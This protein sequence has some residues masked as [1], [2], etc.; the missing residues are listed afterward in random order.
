LNA[1][2]EPVV[3]THGGAGAWHTD[4]GLAQVGVAR[5]ADA[6]Y[7]VLAAGGSA[8]DAVVAA[9]C[10]LEDD[11]TFNAGTGGALTSELT[12]ELDASVMDGATGRSGAVCALAPHRNPVAIARA[13]LDDG[14]HALLA[15][16]GAASFAAAHGYPAVDPTSMITARQRSAVVTGHDPGNTVG[17]VACDA[18]GRLAAATSTGGISGQ[19]PGRVGDAPI[20]GAGTYANRHAAVSCTGKGEAF[21]RAVAAF[22]IC[23]RIESG[24]DLLAAAELGLARVRDAF[25][26]LGGVIVVTAE[27]HVAVPHLTRVMPY[28]IARRGATI[29]SA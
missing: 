12:L 23:D 15:G 20:I 11:P 13:V 4:L 8:L 28:A 22:W 29:A 16:A 18:A 24:L 27:G 26:G 21:A 3:V 9:V 19:L 1:V 14:R 2:V 5:G 7:A 10:V 25:D 6:G 17:A